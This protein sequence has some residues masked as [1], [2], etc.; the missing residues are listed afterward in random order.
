MKLHVD[1]VNN[2]NLAISKVFPEQFGNKPTAM[3]PSKV[4][5]FTFRKWNLSHWQNPY[6]YSSWTCKN[7]AC[8]YVGLTGQLG[9]PYLLIIFKQKDL[10]KRI[11]IRNFKWPKCIQTVSH[12]VTC[13]CFRSQ[14]NEIVYT[15]MFN[16]KLINILY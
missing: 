3:I 8:H 7:I 15:K 5:M 9:V 11:L 6:A 2:N 12:F 4:F 1:Y 13:Y 10:Q 14:T 16:K